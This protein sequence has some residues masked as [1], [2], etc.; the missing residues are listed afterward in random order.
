MN[1]LPLG[2]FCVPAS[3][4]GG[5][6]SAEFIHL[7]KNSLK[8][9]P[10]PLPTSFS[11]VGLGGRAP[12]LPHPNPGKP[13]R[14]AN[15]RGALVSPTNHLPGPDSRQ[16]FLRWQQYKTL[17]R[18]RTEFRPLVFGG[19]GWSWPGC[20]RQRCRRRCRRRRSFLSARGNCWDQ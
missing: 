14:R 10:P 17:R 9:S 19:R 16:I 11:Q 1:Q 12:A 7:K 15:G 3:R 4:T 13:V 20:R 6:A 8:S 5:R 18:R 2:R